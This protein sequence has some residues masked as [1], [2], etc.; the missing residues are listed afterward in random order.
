M[1]KEKARTIS[2]KDSRTRN[3]T[4]LVYPESAPQNWRDILDSQHI[5]WVESPLHDRDLDIN[6]QIK[7]SHWH[8]LVMFEGNKSFGQIKELAEQLNATTP[9]KCSS[10][11]GLIRYMVHLDNLEKE[12]YNQSEIVGHGGIDVVEYLKPINSTRYQ[13]I[14]EMRQWVN[15]VNCTEF[16]DLFD[17]AAQNRFNDWFPLLCDNSAYIMGEFIKSKRNRTMSKQ[18][19][20]NCEDDRTTEK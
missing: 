4:F 15:D 5:Q 1:S 11:R 7:K 12:Q 17:Y 8:I 3:W 2:T 13:L 10:V 9:Q 14:S 6:G 16:C 18:V 20:V 19:I